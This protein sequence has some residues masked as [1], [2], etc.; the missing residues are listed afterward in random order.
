MLVQTRTRETINLKAQEVLRNYGNIVL[1]VKIEDIARSLSLKVIPYPFHEDISGTL[2]IEGNTG[3]IGYNQFESRV[4]RR[5]TIAHELGHF[6]LH[7]DRSAVFLDKQF[8]VHFRS[9]NSKQ[10]EDVQEMEQE[11]NAF[12]A[13]ILMP[14]SLIKKQL[15]DIDF[16]LGSEEATKYLARIFDVSSQ[17]MSYRLAKLGLFDY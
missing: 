3:I 7:K 5:F 11:A 1:P 2:I 12:A 4:R 9:Q 13:A 15:K 8:R 10:S 16:D 17:A 14:E 6:I